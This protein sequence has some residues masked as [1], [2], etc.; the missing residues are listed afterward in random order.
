MQSSR[1]WLK[2]KLWQSHS[3]LSLCTYHSHLPLCGTTDAHTITVI[4]SKTNPEIRRVIISEL[5]SE[6][7]GGGRAHGRAATAR[8]YRSSRTSPTGCNKKKSAE[9]L[10]SKVWQPWVGRLTSRLQQPRLVLSKKR[11]LI[12]QSNGKKKITMSIWNCF[13]ADANKKLNSPMFS[14]LRS[15]NTIQ[16]EHL[17]NYSL[18]AKQSISLHR[19]TQPILT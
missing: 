9:T 1:T 2:P 11:T 8:T 7:G 5:G 17:Q 6:G 4:Q 3:P 10:V 18:K 12:K 16:Q 14:A 15:I 19:H 13:H